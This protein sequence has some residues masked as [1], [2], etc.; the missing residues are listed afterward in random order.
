MEAPMFSGGWIAAAFIL[1]FICLMLPV[2]YLIYY[3][4]KKNFN[5]LI[6]VIGIVAFI[7]LDRFVA[8]L[9]LGQLAPSSAVGVLS[10]QNYAIRRALCIGVIKA[11]GI[12]IALF[13]L[14]KR[15]VTVIV[16]ASF[17]LG[18]SVLDMIYLRGSPGFSAFTQATA[19]NNNGLEEVV[20]TVDLTQQDAFRESIAQLAATPAS[21]YIWRTGAAICAFAA[22]VCIAR[23]LWYS[24]EGGKTARSPLLIPICVV[25]AVVLELPA[26]L[27][28]GG[29]F[30][31]YAPAGISFYVLT[32]LLVLG[33]ILVSRRHDEK[34]TVSDTPLRP[35]R[36]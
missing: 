1:F 20:S 18:Y 22:T 27:Y 9:L 16:P 31:G 5:P 6:M 13:F 17:A 10:P 11:L 14:S 28:F 3:V 25:A 12:W 2:F 15:Y 33:T 34:E 4:F 24:I 29:A 35:R 26:A 19:I 8:S 32:A 21:F 23:L 7:I 30:S 36:R